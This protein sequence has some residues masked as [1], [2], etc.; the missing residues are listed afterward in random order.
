MSTDSTTNVNVK[1][2]WT[3]ERETELANLYLS[4]KKFY[5][6]SKEMVIKQRFVRN[7]IENLAITEINNGGDQS[8]VLEKWK[9]SPE[10]YDKSVNR[11]ATREQRIARREDLKSMTKEQR[12]QFHAKEREQRTEKRTARRLEQI[13]DDLTVKELAVA[14]MEVVGMLNKK[15]V[16]INFSL[17]GERV[18]SRFRE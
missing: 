2:V 12:S 9:M 6:I 15:G 14:L 7:C 16:A 11:R 3:K 17:R 1:M 5:E 13:P 4:G 18:K 8:T 10:H